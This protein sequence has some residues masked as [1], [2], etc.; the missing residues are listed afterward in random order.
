MKNKQNLIHTLQEKR[1]KKEF[2]V[3]AGVDY[4]SHVKCSQNADCDLI[5]LYPTAKH[6]KAENRFLAGYLA[7]GNTNDL[8]LQTASE[9]MPI[10]NRKNVLAGLNGTDPFKINHVLLKKMKQH[11]FVGIHNY[12]TMSLVD[13]NFGMNIE[14]SS[15][16]TDKEIDFLKQAQ[17]ENFFIC[18]MVQTQKQALNMIRAK[19]DMLIFYLGLGEK[20]MGEHRRNLKHDIRQLRELCTACRNANPNIPLLFY[21]ERITTIDEIKLMAKEVPDLDGY[22]LLPVTK[23][24]VSEKQLELEI[25]QLKEIRGS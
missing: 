23:S 9:L 25:R 17:E 24:Y 7:F 21:D 4:L 19:T 1:K 3:V 16:G 20:N 12:P 14:S 11:K 6:T 8:M 18:S 22:C 5:L 15:L 10:I 2:I 13:G